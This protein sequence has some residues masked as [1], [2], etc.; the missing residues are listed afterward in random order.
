MK[1]RAKMN[2][3]SDIRNYKELS[4]AIGSLQSEISEKE[5]SI[6]GKYGYAKSFYSP[7]NMAAMALRSLYASIDWVGIALK[8][9]RRLREMLEK[10]DETEETNQTI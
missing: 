1:K 10:K 9:V 4:R 5:N 6:A 8:T 3:F 7:S 2:D